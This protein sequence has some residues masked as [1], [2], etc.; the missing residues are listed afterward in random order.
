MQVGNTFWYVFLLN[1]NRDSVWM[2]K[3]LKIVLFSHPTVGSFRFWT[4]YPKIC[5][6]YPYISI[7]SIIVFLS[8]LASNNAN[9]FSKSICF[10]F[11]LGLS[12]LKFGKTKTPPPLPDLVYIG[13]L[14]DK[15]IMSF[16]IVRLHTPNSTAKFSI[17]S[18]RLL[19]SVNKIDCRLSCAVTNSSPCGFQQ[20]LAC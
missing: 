6:N 12:G 13:Y 16:S 7:I 1:C 8:S 5:P 19:Q 11:I 17:V 4:Q 3:L 9:F 15:C 2:R 14:R 20:I 10:L 18:C